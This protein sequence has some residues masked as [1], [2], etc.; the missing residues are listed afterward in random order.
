LGKNY[1]SINSIIGSFSL[2]FAIILGLVLSFRDFYKK[3][4]GFLAKDLNFC[5]SR[6]WDI[7][8][9]SIDDG[10]VAQCKQSRVAIS[11]SNL[12]LKI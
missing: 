4:Q 3:S 9:I 11:S 8:A 7:V 5:F 12:D 6:S 2:L 10:L 1:N